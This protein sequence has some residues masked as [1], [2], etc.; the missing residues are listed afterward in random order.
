MAG[1]TAV[2]FLGLMKTA[3]VGPGIGGEFV[4]PF[5]VMTVLVFVVLMFSLFLYKRIQC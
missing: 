1:L 2:M 5:H 3:I 4:R